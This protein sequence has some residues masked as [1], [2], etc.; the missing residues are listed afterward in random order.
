MRDLILLLVHVVATA[1]RLL[2][3]GGVRAVIAESVPHQTSIVDSQT[4]AETRAESPHPRSPD[5]RL[6]FALD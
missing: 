2:E 6:L 5:R 4:L 1:L 3:P